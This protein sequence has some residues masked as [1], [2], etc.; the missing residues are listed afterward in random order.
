MVFHSPS[1]PAAQED[2]VPLKT[3][4]SFEHFNATSFGGP[5]DI[6]W[7]IHWMK[8][9]MAS[10]FKCSTAQTCHKFPFNTFFISMSKVDS[11]V[12]IFYWF[13][14]KFRFSV[15][16]LLHLALLMSMLTYKLKMLPLS[17]NLKNGG[18]LRFENF[19]TQT[20]QLQKLTSSLDAIPFSKIW[21]HYRPM[22]DW[23]TDRGNCQETINA[24]H[25][26]YAGPTLQK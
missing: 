3:P 1:G 14:F 15:K 8:S 23:L 13:K 10:F 5:R 6:S 17:L 4:T 21:K 25:F 11:M 12:N 26:K 7:S 18:W 20:L 24:R 22:T 16:F 2:M 19:D 9:N